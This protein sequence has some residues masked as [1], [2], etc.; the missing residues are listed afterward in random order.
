MEITDEMIESFKD[1]TN[2]SKLHKAIGFSTEDEE[3]QRYIKKL[4]DESAEKR[5]RNKE[6]LDEIDA[7]KNQLSEKDNLLNVKEKETSEKLTGLES[8][9]TSLTEFKNNIFE[10][11]LSLIQDEAL[12]EELKKTG[13]L[14]L[15]EMTL[16]KVIKPTQSL[17][18][19]TKPGEP[20]DISKM[21]FNDLL[22][23]ATEKPDE[24]SKLMREQIRRT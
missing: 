24:Y 4:R 1:K 2:L 8:Q 21:A 3:T 5:I 20:V 19:E 10:K 12:K 11:K 13:S 17:G 18:A 15:V 14:E 9:L 7:L 23:M 6:L 16:E 22:Q